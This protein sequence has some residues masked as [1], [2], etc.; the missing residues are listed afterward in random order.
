MADN[1]P[2]QFLLILT[3]VAMPDRHSS[4]ILQNSLLCDVLLYVQ[5]M[6]NDFISLLFPRC[7]VI[8]GAPLARG[9]QHIAMAAAQA[10]PRFD[11]Q[12]PPEA[13]IRQLYTFAPVKHALTYYKFV[14][15]GGV[16]QLLH[17]LK[18]KN[19]P[20]VGELAGMWFGH[21]L[22]DA[23]YSDSFDLIIPIPLHR[24]KFRQRGYNQCD[25]I[26][27]GLAAALDIPWNPNVLV[28]KHHT[29][30]QT[31][32]SRWER[33]ENMANNFQLTEPTA[34]TDQRILLVDDVVTTGA[35]LG[36]GAKVLLKAGCCEVSVAALATPAW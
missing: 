26:A 15:R 2:M 12:H 31:R 17:A 28:K 24:A 6:V 10:L 18:Y 11:L 30:S 5:V 7:C 34:V 23:S 19:C 35:T 3:S 20:E 33:S 21:A 16:Q 9:E 13:L 4:C 25:Y 32:K 1:N 36:T 29:A 14:R 8:S 22:L 27:K